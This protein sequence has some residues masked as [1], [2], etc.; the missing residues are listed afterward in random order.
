MQHATF[1]GRE[2]T[3]ASSCARVCSA[4]K[5]ECVRKSQRALDWVMWQQIFQLWTLK[6]GKRALRVLTDWK[7]ACLTLWWNKLDSGNSSKQLACCRKGTLHGF[8]STVGSATNGN[9]DTQR[10]WTFRVYSLFKVG[11]N[12]RC[13]SYCNNKSTLF[14][15]TKIHDYVI[16]GA[17]DKS[18]Q[19][20]Q[21]ENW[22]QLE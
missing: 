20:M 11:V 14:I 2:N 22:K 9:K 10:T 19:V 1:L 6:W 21:L 15:L 4:C 5:C 18:F 17:V 16:L 3:F 7:L 13:K 12:R 8:Q